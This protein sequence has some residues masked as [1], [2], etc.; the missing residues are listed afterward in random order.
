M[1]GPGRDRMLIFSQILQQGWSSPQVGSPMVQIC[2]R[3]RDIGKHLLNWDRIVFRRRKLEMEEVQKALNAILQKPF[4][5][6]DEQEKALLNAK[7]NE[8]VAFG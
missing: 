3:I 7:F 6:A 8:Y 1:L 2:R 4:D 5:P